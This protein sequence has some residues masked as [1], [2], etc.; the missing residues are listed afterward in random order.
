MKYKNIE[1]KW[2]GH[3]GFLIQNGKTVYIDPFRISED[4][5]E[6]DIILITHSHYDH[7]SIEDIRKIARNGTVI[8]CT[9]DSQSKFRHIDLK[10][11]L[12]PIEIGGKIEFDEGNTKVWAVHAYNINKTFHEKAEDWVGFILEL[13]EINIY[14]AGDTDNIP[15][16]KHIQEIDIALLP[17]GGTVT[18]NAGEAANAAIVIKPKLALPMHWGTIVGNRNDAEIFVR[19]CSAGG[20][21]SKILEKE[22][23]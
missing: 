9:A 14:H 13:G 2:L 5:P 23:S 8:I 3:S 16:M 1:V 22:T 11:D 21:D 7:C 18:M 15:E 4:L 12:R 19:Q 17:I 6:A 20:I 10:L